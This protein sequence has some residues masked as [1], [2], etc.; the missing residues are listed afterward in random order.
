VCVLVQ[1]LQI[2]DII[3]RFEKK[4]FFLKGEQKT[5]ALADLSFSQTM[6]CGAFVM[7]H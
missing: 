6:F 2:G 3:S 5:E 1:T 7:Y 4:G